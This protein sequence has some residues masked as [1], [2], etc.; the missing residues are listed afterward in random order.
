MIP[1]A[2]N[3]KRYFSFKE[4]IIVFLAVV[5]AVS[6]GVAV[7]V[8]LKREVVINDDGRQITVKT[9]KS[10]VGEVL[11][12][13][14]ITIK[15][16]DYINLKLDAKLQK[17]RRNEIYIKRAVPVNVFVDGKKLNLMTYRDTVGEVLADNSIVMS[18]NDRLENLKPGDKV[19]GNMDIK[20][21]RVK[22]EVVS[23][24]I[25]I[26]Y[27]VI[28]RENNHLDKGTE[29][30]VREGKEGIRE[31]LFRVL[32]EDG[33]EISRKLI[34]DSITLNPIDKI[35]E[36]GTV[37][38]YRTSRGDILR[39]R[40]VLNMRATAYTSS[41]EDTG[42]NPGD[43]GFGITYTG[44]KAKKGIIAVDP[45]IIPLGTRVYVEIPG[46]NSDYGYAVAADIGGAIKGNLI[47]LYFDDINI[48]RNWGCKKV[49]VYL[50]VD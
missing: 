46:K 9:M 26:P 35:V 5:I 18:G 6:A 19:T 15:P 16:C 38:N 28:S 50:L 17:L 4:I 39:Y 14:G 23:E 20:I 36:F 47:D 22:E 13:N 49:N 10:S 21:I 25:P 44:M 30:T 48:V 2:K 41:F 40:K 7:F 43:P 27:K 12:Q 1:L 37:L 31:K 42:K 32:L 45:R 34:N 24:K 8:N 33:K 3:I 29:L 11:E